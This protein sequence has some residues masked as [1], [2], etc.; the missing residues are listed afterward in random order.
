MNIID[1]L[2]NLENNDIN[3]MFYY[4]FLTG[5]PN[6]NYLEH[7]F[8]VYKVSEMQKT[9]GIALLYIDFDN[10]KFINNNFGHTYGDKFLTVAGKIL[11]GLVSES[12]AVFRTGGD[13]F[14]VT[15]LFPA[16]EINKVEVIAK[17]ILNRFRKYLKLDHYE[18]LSTVSIGIALCPNHAT[19][20]TE[21]MKF[22][23]IALFSS[24]NHGKNTFTY[25]NEEMGEA[26]KRKFGI[27]LNMKKALQK[28][29]LYLEFQPQLDI[30]QNKIVGIEAL[31][32]WK[33]SELGD[34]SPAE[35][36]SVAE[37][38]GFIIDLGKWV[39]ENSLAAYKRLSHKNGFLLDLGINVSAAQL[40]GGYFYQFIIDML[41]KYNIKPENIKFEIT[42]SQ[43]M[44]A[45]E[46]NIKKINRIRELGIKISLDDF[47]VGYSSMNYLTFLPIDEIKID[48]S[49]IA[50][51]T[52]DNKMRVLVDSIIYLSH[53]LGYTVTAEGVENKE[54][55]ELLKEMSCDR[56]QGH[57]LSKSLGYDELETFLKKH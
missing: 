6:R 14:V 28:N 8:N 4:D 13:E 9:V 46:E 47:G 21:L 54:Q 12:G 44:Q 41:K 10:F 17:S 31:A 56:I 33:S 19:S 39:I 42:E 36:I 20:L 7:F 26:N 53:R 25:Y 57:L 37:E 5:F 40:H 30:K 50:P 3:K 11:K 15:V 16:R 18:F 35:F 48:S 49:F 51:I 27:F 23:D 34:I 43:I 1:E 52:E 22:A 2:M 55:L 32:R 38:T 45:K 24:K 29:E